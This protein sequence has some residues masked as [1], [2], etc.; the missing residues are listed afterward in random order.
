MFPNDAVGNAKSADAHVLGEGFPVVHV[1]DK[2]NGI[3]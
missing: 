2:A 3:R 1:C